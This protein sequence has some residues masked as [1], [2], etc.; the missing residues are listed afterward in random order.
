MFPITLECLKF[1]RAYRAEGTP[2]PALLRELGSLHFKK[3]FH[4]GMFLNY[5]GM[6]PNHPG[7][8]PSHPGWCLLTLECPHIAM[9]WLLTMLG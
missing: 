2:S 6:D 3:S 1:V 7:I 9:E 4:Y 5:T 8:V